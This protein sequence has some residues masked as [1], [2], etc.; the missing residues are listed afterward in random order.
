MEYLTI[1][2]L[3][4]LGCFIGFEVGFILGYAKGAGR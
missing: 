2:V 1:F 4:G 3:M